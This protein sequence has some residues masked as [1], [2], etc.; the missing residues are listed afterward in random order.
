M[1]ICGGEQVH[2]KPHL[3]TQKHPRNLLCDDI[4]KLDFDIEDDNFGD[5]QK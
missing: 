5:L 4:Q 1:G 3:I 2:Y